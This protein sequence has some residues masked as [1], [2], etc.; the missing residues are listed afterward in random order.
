MA[1][2][3]KEKPEIELLTEISTKL[4]YLVALM[5]SQG[6][7]RNDQIKILVGQGYSNSMVAKL[8]GIPKGTVD[9]IRAKKK[10]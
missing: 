6:K 3:T 10:K 1:A 4:D 2:K 8:L 5:A 7:E 9:V